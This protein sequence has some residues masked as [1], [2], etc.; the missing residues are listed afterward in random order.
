MCIPPIFYEIDSY[1]Y[2]N[3]I[4]EWEFLGRGSFASVFASDSYPDVVLK[5]ANARDAW[6]IYALHCL[7]GVITGPHSLKI[8]AVRYIKEKDIIVAVME[9]LEPLSEENHE[10]IFS[11]NPRSK[12]IREFYDV[13]SGSLL[14]FFEVL[15]N[16]Y[17]STKCVFDLH[18]DNIMQR[19]D[20]TI[21]VT[22]PIWY[23]THIP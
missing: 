22:D 14:E 3:E 16:S 4:P 18:D 15:D 2:L 9:R 8:H 12:N 7:Y 13:L 20:G 6:R 21:V 19:K 5:I 11:T 10:K 1:T 23:G 17:S